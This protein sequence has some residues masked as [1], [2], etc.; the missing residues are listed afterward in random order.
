VAAPLRMREPGCRDVASWAVADLNVHPGCCYPTV[1]ARCD[2]AGTLGP[3]HMPNCLRAQT[4][5]LVDPSSIPS[6]E[7]RQ[8]Q[9]QLGDLTDIRSPSQMDAHRLRRQ[10]TRHRIAQHERATT[11]GSEPG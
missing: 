3:P 6:P 9:H 1:A 2:Q 10:R 8:R 7:H 5:N 4:M 11:H